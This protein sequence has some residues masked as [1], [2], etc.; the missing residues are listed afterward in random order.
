M[1]LYHESTMLPFRASTIWKPFIHVTRRIFNSTTAFIGW[2]WN[3]SLMESVPCS[4][5]LYFLPSIWI[6]LLASRFVQRAPLQNTEGTVASG[7]FVWLLSGL[8]YIVCKGVHEWIVICLTFNRCLGDFIA[9]WL[10]ILSQTWLASK[11]GRLQV[12]SRHDGSA[13]KACQLETDSLSLRPECCPMGWASVPAPAL[14]H[15]AIQ[16]HADASR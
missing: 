8:P 7:R 6:W 13:V 5:F 15:L 3:S 9:I 14:A 10:A 4:L 1:A 2:S 12:Y 11:I 16:K